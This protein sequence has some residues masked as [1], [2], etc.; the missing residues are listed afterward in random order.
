MKTKFL[1][2]GM[3]L[4]A[5]ILLTGF[6]LDFARAQGERVTASDYPVMNWERVSEYGFGHPDSFVLGITALEAFDG[7]LYAGLISSPAGTGIYRS[8]DGMDWLPASEINFGE[9]LPPAPEGCGDHWWYIWDMDEFN[10]QLYA[11]VTFMCTSIMGT[12]GGMIVRSEDGATW[13]AVVTDA[14]G[15]TQTQAIHN[16]AVYQD[17]LYAGTIDMTNGTKIWRS[18]SGDE[19]DW[20]EVTPVNL[21]MS[22]Q[23]NSADFEVYH[24]MLFMTTQ[25]MTVTGE[26][27][28]WS[29]EDG[30]TWQAGP[31]EIFT[32]EPACA[33]MGLAVFS[34]TLFM[35]VTDLPGGELWSTT[36]GITWTLSASTGDSN[37]ATLNPLGVNDGYLYLGINTMDGSPG[38][39]WRT[40][41]G[42]TFENASKPGFDLNIGAAVYPNAA[43]LFQDHLYL[44]KF[45]WFI[46]GSIWR[47]APFYIWLP[48]TSK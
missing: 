15:Y 17:M 46:G 18:D 47:D 31:M 45:D 33:A 39:L 10:Q 30:V 44:A 35:G 1:L 5:G 9:P 25:V 8:E 12:Y 19:G 42:V 20:E 2:I 40:A 43:A 48:S 24:D 27:Q 7:N 14:F 3:I 29:T 11:S 21:A 32:C 37:L 41:D 16:L 38:R 23:F 4:I 36:N 13:E 28:I 34:D 6:G 26:A 22:A